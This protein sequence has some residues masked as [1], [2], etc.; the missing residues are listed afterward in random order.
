MKRI[1]LLAAVA[2]F[3]FNAAATDFTSHHLLVPIAGRT[4]GAFGSQWKTDLVVTNAART[5]EPVSVQVFFIQDGQLSQPMVANLWPRQ[6]A[7]MTDAI[8]GAFGKEQATGIILI[9]SSEP[10]AKLTARARIYNTGSAGG[11][12][13][14]TVQAMPLTKLSKSAVLTSLSGVNGNRTT[15]G[16]A[17][18]D[19]TK[20]G[21]SISLFDREGEF[22]GSF[23]TEVGPYSVL[24]LNDVFS[25]F[26]S[27]PLDGATIQVNSSHGV[28]PYASIVR[29]D[30]GDGDFVAGAATEIDDAHNLVA[31]QCTAPAQLA[32]AALPAVGYSIIYRPGVDPYSTTTTLESRHN[33]TA[34]NVYQFGVFYTEQLTQ[35]QI[36]AL[37]CEP[38]IRV[39]EQNGYV[40]VF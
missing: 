24:R 21:V 20:A 26:Q 11:E 9:T 18:P 37:R 30:S 7:N 40:P 15:V 39:V 3:A 38:T 33:F 27:G 5:G 28:Y 12:Y 32:L 4:P 29:N 10:D 13:G 35:S 25:H 22:R 1:L 31:P 17:N 2:L 8:R 36:A 34:K 16:I 6:S 19:A 14:Q 23:T